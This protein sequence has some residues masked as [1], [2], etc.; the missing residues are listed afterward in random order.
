MAPS[1]GGTGTGDWKTDGQ[2]NIT[3]DGSLQCVVSYV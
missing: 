2:A 1:G 3:G